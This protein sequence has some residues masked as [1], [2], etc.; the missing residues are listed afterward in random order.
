MSP[1][2]VSFGSPVPRGDRLESGE[3]VKRL[4]ALLAPV[5]RFAYPSE[6]QLDA[7]SRAI[8]VEEHLPGAQRLGEPHLAPSVGCPQPRDEPVTGPVGDRDSLGLVVK[9]ND[10]LDGAEDFL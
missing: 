3:T 9:R 8:V 1:N 4:E 10:D 6:R 2:P 7:A 5:A